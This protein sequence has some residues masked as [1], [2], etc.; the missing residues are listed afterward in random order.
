MTLNEILSIENSLKQ[1]KSKVEKLRQKY[2]LSENLNDINQIEELNNQVSANIDFLNN[3]KK[4]KN[5]PSLTI[6]DFL[7]NYKNNHPDF[8]FNNFS[9]SLT[10]NLLFKIYV[11]LTLLIPSNHPRQRDLSAF[12][13]FNEGEYFNNM[14]NQIKDT[15]KELTLE[16]YKGYINYSGFYNIGMHNIIIYAEKGY[17]GAEFEFRIS[18]KII[19]ENL[20]DEVFIDFLNDFTSFIKERNKKNP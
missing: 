4:N 20:L 13:G 8:E 19:E 2:R 5:F 12:W 1:A 17:V 9:Y 3:L 18:K 15:I 14:R 7:I 16:K 11:P 10:S 6:S